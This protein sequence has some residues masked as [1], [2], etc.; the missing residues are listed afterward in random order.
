MNIPI[1]LC[2]G[3]GLDWVKLSTETGEDCD[4]HERLL[5]ILMSWQTLKTSIGE[6]IETVYS[7][8]FKEFCYLPK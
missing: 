5:S 8:S 2:L 3:M 6:C 4:I 1:C 7:H